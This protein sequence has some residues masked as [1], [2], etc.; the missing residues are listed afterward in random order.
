MSYRGKRMRFTTKNNDGREIAGFSLLGPFG[1]FFVIDLDREKGGDAEISVW[2]KLVEQATKYVSTV[3]RAILIFRLDEAGFEHELVTLL[4]SLGF[5]KKFDRIEFQSLIEN[6]PTENGTPIRWE[7]L[8]P[9]GNWTI[10]QAAAFLPTIAQGDP[11]FDPNED[12]LEAIKGYLGDSS[13]TTG[14]N[15]VHIG[16]AQD[17]AAAMVIAQVRPE[18]GWS[19][20]TYMGIAPTFRNK[21]FGK[22]VHRHGFSMFREQGGK[23]YHGGTVAS[24]T[25][26]IRLFQLHGCKEYRRMQEWVYVSGTH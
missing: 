3:P 6:L 24:N 17:K 10:E 22:W 15:C 16:F 7:P 20:I 18:N 9:I 8:S 21:G 11:N 2:A 19:R 25:S 23:L 12:P 26:M 14:P 5:T 1:N 4:P 13:L